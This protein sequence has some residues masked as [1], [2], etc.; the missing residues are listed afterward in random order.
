MRRDFGRREV[1]L[2]AVL[3]GLTAV[4]LSPLQTYVN[5]RLEALRDATV[6]S[7]EETLGRAV[8]YGGVSP[9]VFRSIRLENVAVYR[10]EAKDEVLFEARSLRV[11]FS[12]WRLFTGAPIDAVREIAVEDG[13]VFIPGGGDLEATRGDLSDLLVGDGQIPENLNISARRLDVVLETS[14]TT[15]SLRDLIGRIELS[16]SD[17]SFRIQ[18]GV[19]L[20]LP[21]PDGRVDAQLLI[22][23]DLDQGLETGSGALEFFSLSYGPWDVTRQAFAVR[24]GNDML[25]VRKVRNRDPLEL[26]IDFDLAEQ[27]LVA[28]LLAESFVPATVMSGGEAG[29]PTAVLLDSSL[30]S[31]VTFRYSAADAGIYVDGF[32]HVDFPVNDQNLRSFEAEVNGA[33]E[34]FRGTFLL[35]A[36]DGGSAK[37]T[38]DRPTAR[39]RITAEIQFDGLSV[40]GIPPLNGDMV[41]QGSR[42]TMR[43]RSSD[44]DIGTTTLFATEGAVSVAE[45]GSFSVEGRTHFNPEETQ[46]VEIE[47]VYSGLDGGDFTLTTSLTQVPVEDLA[48]LAGALPGQTSSL[49]V[50]SRFTIEGT[51]GGVSVDAP[52]VS[53]YDSRAPAETYL[54]FSVVQ[55]ENE[56]AIE[57]IAAS[58]SGVGLGGRIVVGEA[59][60]GGHPITLELRHNGGVYLAE[61]EY[62]RTGTFFL[63]GDFET[64]LSVTR[65]WGGGLMISGAVRDAPVV[66]LGEEA[67]LTAD[68]S[69]YFVDAGSWEIDLE[70]LDVSGIAGPTGSIAIRTRGSLSPDGGNLVPFVVDDGV[71]SL[72][73]S[74]SVA[75]PLQGGGTAVS[76]LLEGTERGETVRLDGT[77]DTDGIAIN[78]Q[79]S[80]VGLRRLGVPGLRGQTNF[81]VEAAGYPG[82]L[83][84]RGT[85]EIPRGQFSGESFTARG[86]FTVA[87]RR[88][89]V[90]G[91]RLVRG[92][93]TIDL[94]RATANLLEGTIDAEAR[95]T[96]GIGQEQRSTGL[97]LSYRR[98]VEEPLMQIGQVISDPFSAQIR[99]TGMKVAGVAEEEW[100][101]AV[102]RTSAGATVRGAPSNAVRGQ[103]SNE[104]DFRLVLADPLPVRFQA[105]GTLRN[106]TIEATVTRI[107]AEYPLS[108][109]SE[110]DDDG[111]ASE[112]EIAANKAR[113]MVPYRGVV[114]G[115]LRIVGPVNDPDLF[116]T[117]SAEDFEATVPYVEGLVRAE[118]AFVLFQ[119]KTIQVDRFVVS[120]ESGAE[121]SMEATVSL[122]RWAVAE[123]EVIMETEGDDG[124]P[125]SQNFGAVAVTG[126]AVGRIRLYATPATMDVTGRI[127]AEETTITLI[128][129][130]VEE[131]EPRRIVT[132]D[133]ELVSGRR[134]EFLWPS[135]EV[136]IVRAFARAG[137]E[138]TL[139]SA[140]R[141]ETFGLDGT[142]AIRGGEI[143][144]VNRSFY[145]RSG[146]IVFDEDE[147]GF[148]P[149]LSARAELREVGPRGPVKIFLIVEES[150][151]SQF[152]PRLESSPPLT[153]DEIIALLGGAILEEGST[154]VANLGS[155]VAVTSDV[156]TQFGI[157]NEFER[158]VREALNVDLFSVR[159]QVFQNIVVGS[160][161]QS[162][163][164]LDTT[165]PSLGTYLDNTTLFLGKYLGSDLFLELLV[166]LR[167]RNPL[168]QDAIAIGGMEVDPEI[169][170]EFDTPFF[171]LQ[172]SFFPR[173]PESLF[174]ADN[175]FEFSW[176]F[177]Y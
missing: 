51:P 66:T 84:I 132:V 35:A 111:S 136:P 139:Y 21:G 144:Y 58:V 77:V 33:P 117:L 121:A 22:V 171:L 1:L 150:P 100:T 97:A 137:D 19:A 167:A 10:S 103:L 15:I 149:V 104:G 41:V 114:S 110:R 140:S 125:V 63:A 133:L 57:R 78:L 59:A 24:Y 14:L 2:I 46:G 27:S 23:G 173:T 85:V 37:G 50:D 4:G 75:L 93:T 143:F 49:V 86:R 155:A 87:D 160:L 45:S 8:S 79:G 124:V 29:T 88:L 67:L 44:L 135:Q 102:R 169:G 126:R 154:D 70:R 118:T 81:A 40:A 146:R 55:G 153:D 164:P 152:A 115:S 162:A 98:R 64:E 129:E 36:R 54:Y 147:G 176:Q 73:G 80:N 6:A 122:A 108:R 65:R 43:M 130:N 157:M 32:A 141:E 107:A 99:I 165:A 83:A 119:E 9:S 47:G 138:L 17:V 38:V 76:G 5:G 161:D 62:R 177:S 123:F 156:V 163:V 16:Q 112:E 96:Q 71:E 52:F 90:Q 91:V 74:L 116:G 60:D 18:R 145:M 101:F 68:L 26:S 128:T 113:R 131:R 11:Y 48:A 13:R 31:D 142:I 56:I 42:G 3:L 82:D 174:V 158:Q 53:V 151:L 172:W 39:E 61:A 120:T 175:T 166:E 95:I 7:L 109:D 12:L 34:E 127:T 25:Q 30:T 106:G 159:T 170:L 134:L 148:D 94:T 28:E 168:D 105:A 89:R 92:E 72:V 20:K 69:G